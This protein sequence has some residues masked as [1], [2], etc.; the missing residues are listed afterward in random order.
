MIKIYHLNT[1]K[2]DKVTDN[3]TITDLYD[4]L[5][6]TN[7]SY[8]NSRRYFLRRPQTVEEKTQSLLSNKAHGL[9]HSVAPIAKAAE[10]LRQL[11]FYTLVAEVKTTKLFEAVLTTTNQDED[12]WTDYTDKTLH[13]SDDIKNETVVRSTTTYDLLELDNRFYLLLP[14]GFIDIEKQKYIEKN[15]V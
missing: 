8:E 11:D 6:H 13:V 3:K 5:S 1:D 14:I 12:R 15:P 10:E 9:E 4:Q 2:I 7:V